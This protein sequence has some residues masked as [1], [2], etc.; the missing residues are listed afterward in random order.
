MLGVNQ[1]IKLCRVQ[2]YLVADSNLSDILVS[3][4]YKLLFNY[5]HF[6]HINVFRVKCFVKLKQRKYA[7]NSYI[8]EINH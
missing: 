1:V 8:K 4:A 5:A 3:N 6:E 2:Q 7:F